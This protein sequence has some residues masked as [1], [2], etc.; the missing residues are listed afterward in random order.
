M[1]EIKD[2]VE[3]NMKND[4]FQRLHKYKFSK[5]LLKQMLREEIISDTEFTRALIEFGKLYEVKD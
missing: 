2:T 4:Y 1:A 5:I 3:S